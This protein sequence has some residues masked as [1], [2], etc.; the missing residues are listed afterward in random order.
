MQL[1]LKLVVVCALIY[2]VYCNFSDVTTFELITPEVIRVN[3][4]Y[5]PSCQNLLQV[6]QK[7]Q[8]KNLFV[9]EVFHYLNH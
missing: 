8:L 3:A 9:Q 5:T 7:I 2:S 1:G 6:L 4:I